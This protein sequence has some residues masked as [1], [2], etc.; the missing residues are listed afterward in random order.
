VLTSLRTIWGVE[1]EYLNS[2][3]NEKI[4][5]HFQESCQKWILNKK[6]LKENEIFKLTKEGMLF[7]DAI[8]SDL[9]FL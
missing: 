2:N 9:F 5:R 6:M 7:A 4:N 3:F 1:A 8:S